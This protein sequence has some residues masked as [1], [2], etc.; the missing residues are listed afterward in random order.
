M[1]HYYI[2]CKR[3]SYAI[4]PLCP[5]SFFWGNGTWSHFSS[6]HFMVTPPERAPTRSSSKT[7]SWLQSSAVN[8]HCIGVWY[9]AQV[10]GIQRFCADSYTF[11]FTG[12][13]MEDNH[14]GSRIESERLLSWHFFRLKWPQ[15]W[16]PG[17][18]FLIFLIKLNSIDKERHKEDWNPQIWVASLGRSVRD[19]GPDNTG[20]PESNAMVVD[21]MQFQFQIWSRISLQF[22]L[23][24][25]VRWQ[26]KSV[27][28]EFFSCHS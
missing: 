19:R 16:P 25:R 1:L 9:I 11:A 4:L 28:I 10:K 22:F 15:P 24:L 26:S 12:K 6:S 2:E 8:C 14:A 27:L 20:K 17:H 3:H 18:L 21:L 5:V 13:L 7:D 23:A